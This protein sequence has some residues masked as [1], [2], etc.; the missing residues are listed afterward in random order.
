MG[1]GWYKDYEMPKD[2]K[3][4]NKQFG[5]GWFQ[6]TVTDN[7]FL[8]CRLIEDNADSDFYTNL[9][10]ESIEYARKTNAELKTYN[11]EKKFRY[12]LHLCELTNNMDSLEA[13]NITTFDDLLTFSDNFD[14]FKKQVT[15]E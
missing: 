2:V 14:E 15:T 10:S 11:D 8:C 9:T 7:L 6:D 4:S 12:M 1:R 3:M 5:R 13:C